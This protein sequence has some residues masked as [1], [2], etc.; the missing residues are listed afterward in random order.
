MYKIVMV[1]FD[2]YEI[3]LIMYFVGW[4]NDYFIMIGEIILVEI[5]I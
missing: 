4:I 3:L 1:S 5:G 2:L